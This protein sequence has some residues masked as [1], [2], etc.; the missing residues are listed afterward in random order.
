MSWIIDQHTAFYLHQD[1][2]LLDGL[3]RV[4]K[5]IAFEC[6][7]GYCGSC[8]VKISIISGDVRHRLIPLCQLA[9]DEVLACCC[10][11]NGSIKL[12][13]PNDQ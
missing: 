4:N 8:K 3:I 13:L 10:L 9:D 11:L 2:T 6:K 1:E 12:I 7:Q 5:P